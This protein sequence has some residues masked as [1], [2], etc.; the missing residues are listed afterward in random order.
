MGKGTIQDDLGDGQY[1]IQV[2]YSGRPEVQKVIDD[3]NTKL[4][5]I[6][7]EINSL[8][9]QIENLVTAILASKDPELADVGD[10]KPA[11][12]DT[13]ESLPPEQDPR[14]IARDPNIIPEKPKPIFGDPAKLSPDDTG[15][16]LG[17][18]TGDDEG[19]DES[20]PGDLTGSAVISGTITD[21]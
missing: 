6:V 18:D 3:L 15:D 13:G 10:P 8:Q 11:I 7:D 4:E 20:T 2:N 12:I 14:R 21:T 17:D 5:N 1:R 16:D 19:V 9:D